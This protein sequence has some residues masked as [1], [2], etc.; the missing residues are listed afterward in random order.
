MIWLTGARGMLGSEIAARL[1]VSGCPYTGSD[2]DVDI[3]STHAISSFAQGKDIQWIVNCAAYTAVDKAEAEPETA[4]RL[5]V[6]G[7]RNLG[8]FARSVRAGVI[9]V[10]T[11]YVFSGEGTQP[12]R[13]DDPVGPTGVYGRTKAAGEV[14][15]RQV[16]DNS[17]IVRTAWLYGRHGRNFVY[18]MLRLMQER[19]E[20]GVVSDQRGSPTWAADLAAAIVSIL[21][22]KEARYGTYHFTNDGETTWFG[23]AN[24]IHRLGSELGVLKRDCRIKALSTAEYPTPARRPAY[25]VLSK[26]KIVREFGVSVPA[27]Q[28]SLESFMRDIAAPI[29]KGLITL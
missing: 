15:L 29:E 12:Y 16:C 18:T 20:V 17:I 25:S 6:A 8:A 7:P 28:P 5:N 1:A 23:F 9:H 27:W 13:E 11:D 14:A 10:S 24:Q 2:R 3:S 22:A 21:S 26:E 19:E 4:E